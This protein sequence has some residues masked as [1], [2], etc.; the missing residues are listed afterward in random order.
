VSLTR[1]ARTGGRKEYGHPGFGLG[2][3]KE[4]GQINRA[5]VFGRTRWSAGWDRTETMDVMVLGKVKKRCHRDAL[6]KAE[7]KKS[8]GDHHAGSKINRK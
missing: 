1:P 2:V 8:P 6:P 7:N 3:I 4:A 5:A